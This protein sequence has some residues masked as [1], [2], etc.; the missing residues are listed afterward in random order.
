MEPRLCAG[1]FYVCAKGGGIVYGLQKICTSSGA[2]TMT[3]LE[4]ITEL[5]EYVAGVGHEASKAITDAFL[6]ALRDMLVEQGMKGEKVNI[7]GLGTSSVKESA[8]RSGR[9]AQTGE[10]MQIPARKKLAFSQAAQVKAML[11]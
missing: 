10:T 6:N 8:A 7:P 1:L 2:I 11:N 3:K 9:N 4:I 5:Q